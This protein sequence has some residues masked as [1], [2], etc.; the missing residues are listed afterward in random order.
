MP[1]RART[2]TAAVA[3]ALVV[4]GTAAAQDYQSAYQW[5][6]GGDADFMV[7]GPAT[8]H[9]P[10]V[11]GDA[12][13]NEVRMPTG[14]VFRYFYKPA[15][16]RNA[17]YLGTDSE[18][19]QWR[20]RGGA[21]ATVG[22]RGIHLYG[23]YDGDM[24]DVTAD[25]V[26][27]F[28]DLALQAFGNNNLNNYV[29]TGSG[30]PPW[31]MTIKFDMVVMD[32][33]PAPDEFGEILYF[34]RGSGNGNSWIKMQAVDEAGNALGPWL[35]V[36]PNETV[37]TTPP[38]TVASSSQQVG[39]TSIDVSRL[40][41][42]EFQYLRV[43]NMLPGEPAYTGGGDLNPDFKIMVVMTNEEQLAQLFGGYD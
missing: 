39:T 3:F 40:G 31:A 7:E 11:Q 18:R 10:D 30:E 32:N 21:H 34:E 17:T 25:D 14:D 8:G 22:L 38:T 42:E 1:R 16:V 37:Q 9:H 33:D 23:D 20:V 19:S 13:L 5:K 6:Y 26:V 35:V 36:G 15:D 41:V 27:G 2:G 24:D 12:I 28:Q 4:A 43:S 29:D